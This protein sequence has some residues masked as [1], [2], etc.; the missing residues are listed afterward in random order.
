MSVS[1]LNYSPSIEEFNLLE[2]FE[3]ITSAS[4]WIAQEGLKYVA[5]YVAHRYR[6]KYVFLG[7]PARILADT[8]IDYISILSRGGLLYPSDQLLE[9]AYVMESE[10]NAF[11]G[12]SLKTETFI[13]KTVAKNVQKKI[14]KIPFEVLLCLVRT[15]TYIRLRNLNRAIFQKSLERNK[16]K[17]CTK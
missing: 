9:V 14:D 1:E 10:F 3:S 12:D 5:G 13:F 7:N 11:H 2:E 8:D 4:D 17:K 15:R 6:E 16:K